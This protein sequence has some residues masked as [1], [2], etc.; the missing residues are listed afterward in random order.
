LADTTCL[1]WRA[2]RDYGPLLSA[3]NNRG[4]C[5]N[6]IMRFVICLIQ[7]SLVLLPLN[8]VQAADEDMV[9]QVYLQFDPETG[10]F[11][12][13]RDPALSGHSQNSAAQDQQI[14][15]I[16][17]KQDAL[18]SGQ[19][20]SQLSTGPV[21]PGEQTLAADGMNDASNTPMWIAGVL[22]AGLLGGVVLLARRKPQQT[23]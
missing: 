1:I 20:D 13:T 4:G 9:S 6:Y 17:Q 11:V 16:Q 12:T 7:I 14:Q 2:A 15:L 5:M 19:Q 21:M 10:E 8:A 23:T 18:A 22:I 3:V